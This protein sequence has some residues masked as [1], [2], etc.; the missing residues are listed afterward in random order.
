MERFFRTWAGP[1]LLLAWLRRRAR[2]LA[3]AAVAAMLGFWIA[4]GLHGID[5]GWHWDEGYEL[6][7]VRTSIQ[8]LLAL[9]QWYTYGNVYFLVGM[10]VVFMHH[11]GFLPA[12]WA[13]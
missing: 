5:F 10:A 2:P 13:E 4:T 3:A 6:A 12:F 1:S 8:K 7:G 9:P 11:L